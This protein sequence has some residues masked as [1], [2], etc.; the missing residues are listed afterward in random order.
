MG[1]REN[2][3]KTAVMLCNPSRTVSNQSEEAYKRRMTGTG[4]TFQDYQKPRVRCPDCAA[5]L[6]VDSLALH[7][8][9]QHIVGMSEQRETPPHLRASYVSRVIY[10]CDRAAG[11]LVQGVSGK[12][13]DADGVARAICAPPRVEHRGHYGG[14]KPP[15][16]TVT[17]L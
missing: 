16:P 4:L 9:T 17:P 12:G 3:G 6:V 15:P 14:W 1:L 2:V 5:D 11:V 7:R 10:A 8:H 13:G